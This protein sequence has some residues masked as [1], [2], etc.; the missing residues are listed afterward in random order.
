MSIEFRNFTYQYALTDSPALQHINLTLEEGRFYGIIGP[1]GSGKTT[2]CNAVVGLIPGFY[3]GKMTGEVLI[4]GKNVAEWEETSLCRKVGYVF[5]NPFTQI[6]GIRNTV[7]EELIL[8]LEN[9][10]VPKVELV[11]R[12][13]RVAREVGIYDIIDKNPNELSGG[14]RQRVAFA[15]ILAM[16]VDVYV[17]DE[18]TS[19]LDPDGTENIFRAIRSLKEK[20]K[21]VMLIEHKVDLMAEY[22]DEMIVLK[23]GEIIRHGAAAE[24]LSEYELTEQGVAVPQMTLFA[25][26]MQE[27]GKPL[28]CHPITVEQAA[29]AVKRRISAEG[30]A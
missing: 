23:N 24:V 11:D 4:E 14:Q 26:K 17:I 5:Q 10:S 9:L 22:A 3:R 13:V 21:T 28:D 6:S 8:G 30:R 2:L 16:D 12:A 7:L 18:P 29:D 25:H 19:Q 1:N 27:S 15:S 20:R